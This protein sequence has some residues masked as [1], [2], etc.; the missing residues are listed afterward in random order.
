MS[1]ETQKNK[2][3]ILPAYNR[4]T[5]LQLML[6]IFQN[7]NLN[8]YDFVFVFQLYWARNIVRTQYHQLGLSHA[9]FGLADEFVTIVALL[10]N[11]EI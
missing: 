2:A 7:K 5:T 6:T 10:S 4:C 1:R 8:K 11:N 3:E 9:I